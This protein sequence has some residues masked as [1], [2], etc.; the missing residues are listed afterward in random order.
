MNVPSA[1][2]VCV[3]DDD[4]DV[5][6]SPKSQSIETTV[7]SESEVRSV[8]EHVR[9]VHGRTKFGIGGMFALDPLT[10]TV[11]VRTLDAPSSSVTVTRTG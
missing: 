9:D 5:A 8:N 10:L 11:V 1:A 6:P 2:Y 7:P 4:V 3:G